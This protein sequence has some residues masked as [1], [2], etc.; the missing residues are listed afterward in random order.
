MVSPVLSYLSGSVVSLADIYQRA[1]GFGVTSAHSKRYM[2]HM[3][4]TYLGPY[5]PRANISFGL[6]KS[7]QS[8]S[9]CPP[10]PPSRFE[11]EQRDRTIGTDGERDRGV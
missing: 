6:N 11:H 2:S 7:F 8:T 4:C 9:C 5:S 1:A 3:G 10:H